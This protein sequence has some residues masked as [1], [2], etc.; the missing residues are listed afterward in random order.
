MLGGKSTYTWVSSDSPMGP[1]SVTGFPAAVPSEGRGLSS[2]ARAGEMKG[3]AQLACSIP[4]SLDL[5]GLWTGSHSLQGQPGLLGRGG[6]PVSSA[7][8]EMAR[9]GIARAGKARVEASAHCLCWPPCT[10]PSDPLCVCMAV[11]LRHCFLTQ[12]CREW[13]PSGTGVDLSQ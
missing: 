9:F 13:E 11:S 5:L 10:S 7:T 4:C 1:T 3:S 8:K 6:C 12:L 2:R